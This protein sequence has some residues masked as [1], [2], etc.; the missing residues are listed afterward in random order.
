MKKI[1]LLLTLG[2]ALF[3][4]G[5]IKA[6]P[7]VCDSKGPESDTMRHD[8]DALKLPV[9][10][11]DAAIAYLEKMIIANATAWGIICNDCPE[12]NGEPCEL[13]VSSWTK[14]P[15]ITH[16]GDE[17]R[18]PRQ[19]LEFKVKC[20]DCI[21]PKFAASIPDPAGGTLASCD[22]LANVVTLNMPGILI[23]DPGGDPM[24]MD[25]AIDYWLTIIL[26][27]NGNNIQGSALWGC[28]MTQCIDMGYEGGCAMTILEHG[29]VPMPEFSEESQG[30]SFS[31]VEFTMTYSCSACGA[32]G[33]GG[34][35]G[36]GMGKTIQRKYAP[37]SSLDQNGLIQQMFPNPA[38]E[39]L[40]V[41]L[42]ETGEKTV[43]TI[44]DITGKTVFTNNLNASPEQRAMLQ[45]DIA[46][47]ASGIYYLNVI[48]G[49]RHSSR[50]F[51]VEK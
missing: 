40:S 7:P 51:V 29:D 14:T 12:P 8:I 17:Y 13:V 37:A 20:L 23:Y 27:D 46:H 28:A 22:G 33:E 3:L 15:D 41:V 36:T 43:V 48:S 10:S 39:Y 35:D 50:E 19:T 49:D 2:M 30:W 45:I 34:G 18:A 26:L 44:V 1:N 5:N 42:G 6:Q 9:D 31:P 25:E 4:F 24:D 16:K 11:K 47:L 38:S 21:M 32:D